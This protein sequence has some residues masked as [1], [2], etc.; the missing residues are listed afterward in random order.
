MR[1]AHASMMNERYFCSFHTRPATMRDEVIKMAVTAGDDGFIPPPVVKRSTILAIGF[2][3]FALAMIWPPLILM[4]TY[5]LSI[6]VPYS[7]RVN[8]DPTTRRRLYKE[9]R[10]RADLPAAYRLK[11]DEVVI[12]ERYWVNER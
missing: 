7:W 11:D 3:V 2:G 8:D 4:A 6:L 10:Q 12:N 1:D 5:L 9:F